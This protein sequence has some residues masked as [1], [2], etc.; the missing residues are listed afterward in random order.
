MIKMAPAD[1]KEKFQS[2]LSSRY[3]SDEMQFNFSEAKKF[4]TWRRLWIWLAKAESELGLNITAEQIAEMEAKVDQI[5]FQ[6]AEKEE[7]IRKHDVMAHVYTFGEA[8]P[9]AKGKNQVLRP[10]LPPTEE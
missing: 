5:D 3:C 8:C 1:P 2:P 9:S 7:R 6:V 4:T 10:K